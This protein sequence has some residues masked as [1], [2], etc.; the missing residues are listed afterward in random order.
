MGARSLLAAIF[1]APLPENDLAR[2]SV[3]ERTELARA[4]KQYRENN[5][6][7]AAAEYEIFLRQF[8]DSPARAYVFFQKARSVNQFESADKAIHAYDEL[9]DYYPD[10]VRYAAPALYFSAECHMANRDLP[11][12]MKVWTEMATDPDY[13]KHTITAN[14]LNRLAGSLM[15][16][17]NTAEALK[18]YRQCALDFRSSNRDQ[19]FRALSVLV[20][21]YSIN[22]PDEPELRKLYAETGGFDRN[23]RSISPDAD[24]AQDKLYWQGIWERVG[25]KAKTYPI[26]QIDLKRKL[27]SYWAEV[28]KGRFPEWK[29]FQDQL[30]AFQ[31]DAAWTP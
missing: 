23:L 15:E 12:A 5:F 11:N 6:E 20:E 8:P 28:F 4:D 2:L 25:A 3:V 7:R 31:R 24:V 27:L 19:A 30:S 29:E 26:E 21:H 18:F 17:R 14:A 13:R 10:Q 1:D 22:A 9:L 16:Q